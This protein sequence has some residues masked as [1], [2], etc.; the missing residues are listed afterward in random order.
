L[1]LAVSENDSPYCA[2]CFYSFAEKKNLLIFKSNLETTHIEIALRN[3]K[4]AGT[5]IPDKLDKTRIQGVQFTGEI[6]H[7][8]GDN[9]TTAKNSYYKKYPFAIA[10]AGEL[11]TIE[12][13]SIKFTDN[14]LGFGKKLAWRK[15]G[16]HLSSEK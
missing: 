13:H 3:H 8:K 10:F 5:I 7:A 1:T 9:L 14:K 12:L 4:V 16:V 11:W 6:C 2:N 15:D